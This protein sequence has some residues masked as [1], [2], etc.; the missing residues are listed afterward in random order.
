[1][2]QQG[3]GP[4]G[5][6]SAAE[7]CIRYCNQLNLGAQIV[8]VAQAIAEKMGSVDGLAGRSPLSAAAA[9]IY[10]ASHLMKDSRTAKDI[11]S[12]VGVSDG[13]IRTSYKFLEAKKDVLIDPDWLKDGKGDVENLPKP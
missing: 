6:T 4:T 3:L 11:A 5:S 13:T 9:C 2:D 1:M 12:V 8:K 7:L 10:F